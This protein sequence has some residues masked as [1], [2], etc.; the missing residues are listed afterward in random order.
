ME[1]LEEYVNWLKD[2]NQALYDELANKDK[3][4]ENLRKKI[5]KYER[6]EKLLNEA[7]SLKKKA[8]YYDQLLEHI[9]M[10]VGEY[11]NA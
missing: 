4:I 11:L 2:E 5:K 9:S 7:E 3:E 8:N 10:I 1:Y 6:Q